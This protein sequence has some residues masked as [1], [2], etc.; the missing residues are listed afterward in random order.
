MKQIRSKVPVFTVAD[1]LKVQLQIEQLAYELWR[2]R[3]CRKEGALDNWRQAEGDVLEEF[4]I[5]IQG[6][7]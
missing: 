5:R 2:A 3:G 1:H 4:I 7:Q 6:S